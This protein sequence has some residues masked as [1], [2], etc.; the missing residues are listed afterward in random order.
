MCFVVK[1]NERLGD[2]MLIIDHHKLYNDLNSDKIVFLKAQF[3]SKKD[4]STY[5]ASKLAYDLFNLV[6]DV[7]DMDWAACVGILGDMGYKHWQGFFKETLEKRGIEMRDLQKLMGLIA[8]CEVVNREQM[9]QLFWRFYEAAQ[10]REIL[11]QNKFGNYVLRMNK[12]VDSLVN[13]FK[14]DAEHYPELQLHIYLIKPK[15]EGIKSYVVN[16]LS[17]SC[18]NETILLIQDTGDDKLRFSARR[19]DGKVKLND[20]LEKAVKEIPD[21]GAGGHVPAAA[22]SVPRKHVEKFK[23]NVKK[24]L[25]R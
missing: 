6:V 8:A 19:Q 2:G 24:L 14:K 11:T 3:F 20:L 12:E 1:N 21:A 16:E 10:P 18:P 17:Q 23:E 15:H 22:G 4:S 7:T 9:P 13:G 5:A 25:K